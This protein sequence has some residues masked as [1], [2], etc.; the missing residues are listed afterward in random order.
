MHITQ[1]KYPRSQTLLIYIRLR[2]PDLESVWDYI[3]SRRPSNYVINNRHKWTPLTRTDGC[4][5]VRHSPV[6]TRRAVT[7]PQD[8]DASQPG[9]PRALVAPGCRSG[10]ELGEVGSGAP[11]DLGDWVG[12]V[13]QGGR[14]AAAVAEA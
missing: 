6:L 11:V 9:E 1:N 7:R 13:A 10:R 12:V 14:A 2:R 5:Q 4:S 8:K 3:C